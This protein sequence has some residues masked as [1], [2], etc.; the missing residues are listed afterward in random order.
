MKEILD[1]YASFNLWA[2]ERLLKLVL[3]LDENMQQQVVSSS[4]PGLYASF[5][6]IWDTESAWW[7]RIKLQ[8][9]IVV[10]SKSFTPSMQEI[11]NGLLNQSRQWKDWVSA[12]NEAQLEHVF[13]YHNSK[14]E[15]FKNSVWKTLLHVFNH[16][17]YHRGQIVTI[18][19]QVGVTKIPET[20]FIVFTR[21]K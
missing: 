9:H 16:G 12:A 7:Q 1:R 20:D 10:P 19:H 21:K 15:Y 5:L 2:N 8:E 4:F 14:K 3:T 6:H 18:L 11:A 13:A 17:T